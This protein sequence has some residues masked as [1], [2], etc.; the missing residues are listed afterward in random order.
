MFPSLSVNN[1]GLLVSGPG[2]SSSTSSSTSS[3]VGGG[4]GGGGGASFLVNSAISALITL[5]DAILPA[6]IIPSNCLSDIKS[7]DSR[8]T[9]LLILIFH[10]CFA[11]FS[12][13][14]FFG[15]FICRA[16]APRRKSLILS[17]PF[18]HICFNSSSVFPLTLDFGS[19]SLSFLALARLFRSTAR[20]C[21]FNSSCNSCSLEVVGGGVS[22]FSSRS[23]NSFSI[24]LILSLMSSRCFTS[25][26]CLSS[27]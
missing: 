9:G 22:P 2:A 11:I 20:K 18:I 21:S 14:H 19:V 15:S 12:L 7:P 6:F 3:D 16:L 10:N 25:V 8:K 26:A 13:V 24:S 17:I 27:L 5:S 23:F 1:S 4:G